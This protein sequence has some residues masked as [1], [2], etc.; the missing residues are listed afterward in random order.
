M[1]WSAS[2]RRCKISLAVP[3][4]Q[5]YEIAIERRI[6][7]RVRVTATRRALAELEIADYGILEAWSDYECI[8]ET[9]TVKIVSSKVVLDSPGK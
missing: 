4:I 1:A 7:R 6:I 3:P 5:T 9:D 8:E 2:P